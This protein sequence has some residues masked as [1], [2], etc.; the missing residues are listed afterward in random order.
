MFTDTRFISLHKNSLYTLKQ[1]L[2]TTN[3]DSRFEN[4][5]VR[6][7]KNDDA[8]KNKEDEEVEDDETSNAHLSIILNTSLTREDIHIRLIE[9]C[10]TFKKKI[11][12]TTTETKNKR[13]REVEDETSNTHL[14]ITLQ[15]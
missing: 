6:Y 4:L 11:S 1:F 5:L 10:V 8:E 15:H 3:H 12:R 13:G 9:H 14:S 7:V 2:Q